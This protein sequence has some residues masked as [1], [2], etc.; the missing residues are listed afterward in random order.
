MKEVIPVCLA[1]FKDEK[2]CLSEA[3][4]RGDQHKALLD[5]NFTI[6]QTFFL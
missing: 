6:V 2:K 3:V 1:V 4:L 5:A